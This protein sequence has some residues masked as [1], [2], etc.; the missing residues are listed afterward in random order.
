MSNLLVNYS[1][2]DVSKF[3]VFVFARVEHSDVVTCLR[4]ATTQ[5]YVLTEDQQALTALPNFRRP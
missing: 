5:L 3:V 2:W 1:C 4:T